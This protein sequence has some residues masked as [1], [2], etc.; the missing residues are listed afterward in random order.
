[1]FVSELCFYIFFISLAFEDDDGASR[2]DFF[3]ELYIV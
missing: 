1:M 2:G 3:A